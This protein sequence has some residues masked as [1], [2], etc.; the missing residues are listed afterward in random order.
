[1]FG[2]GATHASL[3]VFL[4]GAGWVHYNPTN[5]ISA[6][7]DSI[8]AAIGRYPAQAVPLSGAWVGKAQDYVGMSVNVAVR[9]LGN[10]T[11][12]RIGVGRSRVAA[13]QPSVDMSRVAK[14][15]AS[16]LLP[17]TA[18]AIGET[19]ED[20]SLATVSRRSSIR[21]RARSSPAQHS[22]VC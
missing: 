19:L 7:F 2:S 10:V 20:A 13:R 15:M 6:G 12:Q 21:I 5:R 17:T 14:T 4:P 9:K 8:L 22:P 1:M 18:A 3:Q 11:V 16:R